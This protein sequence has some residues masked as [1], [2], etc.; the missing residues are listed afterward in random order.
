MDASL[1]Y[2]SDH[3]YICLN[4]QGSSITPGKGY[5]KLNNSHLLQDDLKNDIRAIINGTVNGSF[6]SYR[7][8]W[9]TVKFKIKDH[10]IRYGKKRKSDS[11][12]LKN[13]LLKDN[14]Y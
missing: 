6:D 8:L 3:S 7:E 11:N 5:W 10:A 1:G 12:L 4:I 2:K 13:N 9:D 14:G